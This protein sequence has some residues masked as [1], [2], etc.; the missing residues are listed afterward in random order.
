MTDNRHNIV[1][2]IFNFKSDEKFVRSLF[3]YDG[4]PSNKQISDQPKIKPHQL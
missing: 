1:F 3:T 4:G 2:V